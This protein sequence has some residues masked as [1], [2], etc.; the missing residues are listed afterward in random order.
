[1]R[2]RWPIFAL[3]CVLASL[4]VPGIASAHSAA[5]AE[6]RVW[7]FDLAEQIHVGGQRALTPELHQGC[8]PR[9]YDSAS[10]SPLAAKGGAG[11]RG[12]GLPGKG[13]PPDGT[14]VRDTGHGTGTI[15]DY[16]GKGNAKTDFDFHDGEAAGNP[17]AHDWDWNQTPPRGPARPL[18][19]G[20]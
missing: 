11:A 13:G 17:H 20:E 6:N 19:P 1:M 9:E 8:E 3:L 2:N 14:L 5:G 4:L 15:R 16:D 12:N 18:K 7:G 10:G